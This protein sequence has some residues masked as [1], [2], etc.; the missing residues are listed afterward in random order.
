MH[1]LYITAHEIIQVVQGVEGQEQA[2][3]LVSEVMC[4]LYVGSSKPPRTVASIPVLLGTPRRA[5]MR[6]RFS[7]VVVSLIGGIVVAGVLS[8]S[9][10]AGHSA[11][12]LVVLPAGDYWADADVAALGEQSINLT[13]GDGQTRE[14]GLELGYTS[15]FQEG[16][17]LNIT[18]LRRGQP[19][20]ILSSLHHGKMMAKAIE[21][22]QLSAA[23]GELAHSGRYRQGGCQ[24]A[25]VLP[26]AENGRKR[27]SCTAAPVHGVPAIMERG[28]RGPS[29][30]AA[31][32]S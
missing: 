30:I 13:M 5:F 17:V 25:V 19:V 29:L 9:W 10:Q 20:K 7:E 16:G 3:A 4:G 31:G 14:L 26:L 21:I 23:P 22:K 1:L 15:V 28:T 8:A 6:R 24:G 12:A 27:L 18:H 2:R 32:D 11:R